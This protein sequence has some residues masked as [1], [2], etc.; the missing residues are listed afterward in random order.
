MDDV[1]IYGKKA[2]H[3][4]Q[5]RQVINALHAAGLQADITKCEF[6]VTETKFLGL[7]LSTTGLKMDPDKVEAIRTWETPRTAKEVLSFTS[8]CSFY[9]RFIGGFSRICRPLT[10]LQCKDQPFDWSEACQAAFQLLKDTVA[11]APV[12]MHFDRTKEIFL[13]TDSSDYVIAGVISQ[14]GPDG[15]LHPVAF[16][17]RK[18]N[19]A[20]CNYEIYDKE[21]LA[22]VECFENWRPELEGTPLPIQV[23]TDHKSLEYF[24]ST[25]KLTRRQA[26]WALFLGQFNFKVAYRPGAQNGK[27]DALTRQSGS[28]PVGD[29][30][31]DHQ[32]YQ[33][34]T[35]L[36]PSRLADG[37][38]QDLGI[39]SIN[40]VT[41]QDE[42]SIAQ[43]DDPICIDIKDKLRA[44]KKYCKKV[45]LPHCA[46]KDELVYYRNRLWVPES[47][48]TI[49][50]KIVHDQPSVGHPGIAK[51]L[52]HL[53]QSY[54]WP[55][56]DLTVT[57]YVKNCH[58]CG[59]SKPS[60]QKYNGLLNSLPIPLQPWQDISL[61]FVTGLP[62]NDGCDAVLVVVDRLTKERHFIACLAKDSGTSAEE[63]AYLLISCV[64]RLHG[65]PDRIVS[66][67]GPQFVA[68]MWKHLCRILSIEQQLS[69][70]FHPETDGQTEIANAEMER[71]LRCYVNY[72]QD[73]WKRL[74]PMAEFAINN[75][76]SATTGITPF[77]ANKG[78]NPRMS[79]DLKP[80]VDYSVQG[81]QKIDREQAEA[82]A[83]ELK[84]L[85][86]DLRANTA[87]AQSRM[88]HFANTGRSP[89]PNYAIGDFVYVDMRNIKTSRPSKKLD[90][91]NMG[92][93]EII[94][95]HGAASYELDLRGLKIH[96]V[97]HSN[98][99][100]LY[101]N[102]PLPGQTPA[103]PEPVIIDGEE[104]WE[105]ERVLDSAIRWGKLWYRVQ[106]KD[107][108]PRNEWYKREL[109]THSKELLEEF[110]GTYPSRPS[111]KDEVA[112]R[113]RRRKK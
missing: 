29:D 8:F 96:P 49:L 53:Q 59:R 80:P 84:A 48:Q 81:R 4:K 65:L 3:V 74:L 38:L 61:D 90:N 20:Q 98:L 35:I 93:Y 47:Y 37:V 42:I 14:R 69:T 50:L 78:Y 22:I 75:S 73:N 45:S 41:I 56:M 71:Y 44:G 31:E 87:L 82:F 62:L 55:R 52:Y 111:L 40:A 54:Y 24:M 89:A 10:K 21:L 32:K 79:F 77:F 19:P 107:H 67:R 34:Q 17:S 30:A 12:L 36:D 99:L 6:N 43:S 9:R 26:R 85:W 39:S 18:M 64:W 102:N 100:R 7:I 15:L 68:E 27:A 66:D 112:V 103:E 63:T 16:F 70:A 46:I 101:P 25:K 28:R 97:F 113:G 109:F 110:H 91:K 33:E 5:V 13:E 2:D 58:V 60:R 95:R 108:P 104:E 76:V 105:V 88:E 83:T 1:L 92:P 106:W 94:K 72:M 86:E 23:L 57:Q 11:S 51:T